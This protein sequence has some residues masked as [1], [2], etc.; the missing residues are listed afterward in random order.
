MR[1]SRSWDA[2]ELALGEKVANAIGNKGVD[3]GKLGRIEDSQ[4][5]FD[6]V[7]EEF[8]ESPELA[9][10]KQV[11]RAMYNKSVS[12][13]VLGRVE[14]ALTACDAV[15]ARFGNASELDFGEGGREDDG[16]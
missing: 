3:L 4:A 11:A 12:L 15:M 8:G 5:A 2:T 6:V 1:S 10:R 7:V 14:D 16:Q 9:L 13:R